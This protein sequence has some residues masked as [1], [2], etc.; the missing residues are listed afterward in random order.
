MR[1][2]GYL[3][4]FR[5]RQARI[6]II[7]AMSD[8]TVSVVAQVVS[9]LPT[10]DIAA[11]VNDIDLG[12]ELEAALAELVE[13]DFETTMVGP[14]YAVARATGRGMEGF[15]EAWRDWTSPFESLSI[16]PEETIDAGGGKVV[17]LVRQRGVTKTGGV[18]IESK[19]AAVWTVRDGR[20]SSVEFHLDQEFAKRSAGLAE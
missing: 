7:G 9:I 3:W 14:E 6:G 16:E 18:E 12:G 13:P 1:A 8:E 20:V 11:V 17:T 5:R 10:D 15:D 2:Q 4:R 19:A